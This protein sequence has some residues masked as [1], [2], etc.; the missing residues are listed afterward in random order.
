MSANLRY[1]IAS[2]A[3]SP[4]LARLMAE[5]EQ[6]ALELRAVGGDDYE[7]LAE[8]VERRWNGSYRA[9]LESTHP[10]PTRLE[11]TRSVIHD[12]SRVGPL[13]FERAGDR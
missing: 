2:G 6:A 5:T 12:Y 9:A 7:E 4:S 13:L 3:V 8:E 10:M 1:A 11:I